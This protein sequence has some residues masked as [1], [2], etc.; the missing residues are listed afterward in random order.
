MIAGQKYDEWLPLKPRGENM[1]SGVKGRLHLRLLVRRKKEKVS[2]L[3]PEEV[4]KKFKKNS[5]FS[6]WCLC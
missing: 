2:S 6:S 4:S 1:D 5:K 3:F